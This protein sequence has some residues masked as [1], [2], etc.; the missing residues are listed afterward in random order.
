M[1]ILILQEL[2]ADKDEGLHMLQIALDNLQIVLPNTSV[3]GTKG[4]SIMS[5]SSY[6]VYPNPYMLTHKI[7][8]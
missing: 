4:F 5:I 2:M 1:L 7:K 3:P 8:Y 6:K